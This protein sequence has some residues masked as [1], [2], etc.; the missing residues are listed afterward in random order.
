MVWESLN[1]EGNGHVVIR[2]SEPLSVQNMR[3][4]WQDR[5]GHSC[6]SFH[7]DQDSRKAF[8]LVKLQ[9][10]HTHTTTTKTDTDI[11]EMRQASLGLGIGVV[12]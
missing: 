10:T 11:H 9:H 6:T 3:E 12:D 4:R 5:E 2:N 7:E 1:K 8:Q